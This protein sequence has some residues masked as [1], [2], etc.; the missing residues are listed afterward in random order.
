MGNARCGRHDSATW[1]ILS[2]RGRIRI[3]YALSL[4]HTNGRQGNREGHKGGNYTKPV[5]VHDGNSPAVVEIVRRATPAESV[6]GLNGYNE[7][8]GEFAFSAKDFV[9]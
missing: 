1:P 5:S 7:I 2:D 6:V 8:A 3:R 4:S 9:S